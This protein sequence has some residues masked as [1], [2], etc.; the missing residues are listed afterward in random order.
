MLPQIEPK[1]PTSSRL[2]YEGFRRITKTLYCG[3]QSVQCP[4][5]L[6]LQTTRD[7][8]ETSVTALRFLQRLCNLKKSCL[9]P[10]SRAVVSFKRCRRL[11]SILP[12]Q[13]HTVCW[14]DRSWSHRGTVFH[15]WT[16]NK[17]SQTHTHTH[18][19]PSAVLIACWTDKRAQTKNR[20]LSLI[21]FI[22]VC[23]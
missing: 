19:Q 7:K 8:Y 6:H 4:R 10:I 23:V 21:A 18:L 22:P 16:A 1:R 5:S 12:R 3:T 9:K 11:P 13:V 14:Y 20:I 15:F 17:Q 2:F